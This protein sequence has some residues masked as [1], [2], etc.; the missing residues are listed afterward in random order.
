MNRAGIALIAVLGVLVVV[1]LLVFGSFFTTTIEQNITRNDIVSTQAN[2]VAQAGLQKYKAALFQNYR[3]REQLVDQDEAASD[4]STVCYNNITAGIDFDR[5]GTPELFD[6]NNTI[7]VGTETVT[8]TLG[9][10]IGTYTVRIF[11]STTNP[12]IF[13]I[14]S[15]G[16][17][18][19]ARSKVRAV[20]QLAN[21]GY[22]DTAVFAGKGQANKF[23]NGGAT[24]RGGIYV[25][26]DPTMRDTVV[27]DATGNFSQTNNY[28]LNGNAYSD[29]V[30]RVNTANRVADNLCATMRVQY[31][32]MQ[33]GGS[34]LLG[35]TTNKLKGVYV[36]RGMG[37]NGSILLPNAGAPCTNNK[38][39][40]TDPPPGAFDLANPPAF[41]TLDSTGY[42]DTLSNPTWRQC[43]QQD[44]Q[45]NGGLTLRR[46]TGVVPSTTLNNAASCTGVFGSSASVVLTTQTVNC[47]FTRNGV[48]GGFIYNGSTDPAN[49]TVYDTLNLEGYN[50]TFGQAVN[51]IARSNMPSSGV[52]G[53]NTKD[54]AALVVQKDSLGGGDISFTGNFL[55]NTTG[56]K[57]YPQHVLG[58]VAENNVYQTANTAR[59]VMA[60]VYAGNM[61]RMKGSSTLLGNIVTNSF[62][63]T[64]A[65]GSACNAGQTAEI[66]YVNTGNNKP[67]IMRQPERRSTATFKVLS[68]ERR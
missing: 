31:G 43:I 65:G 16:N 44:A 22:M 3:W 40:C 30:G 29:V 52:A 35:S 53:S 2:Y 54:N 10:S 26:G 59:F 19:G 60:P 9:T 6:A 63:T 32:K 55:P 18:G 5:D 61:Y 25:V 67:G 4:T 56:S 66:V 20:F 27:V 1:G 68:Y 42:C 17:S 38:G 24:I 58:L 39:I 14:E 23:I 41:P 47:T 13:T 37:S 7:N 8:D 51:F 36:D 45:R 46:G 12:Q 57:F 28:N 48:L 21:T 62:C 50:L 11:R 64:S 15:V 33:V 34:V 49:L